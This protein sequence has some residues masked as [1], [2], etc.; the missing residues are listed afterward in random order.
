MITIRLNCRICGH[1]TDC[2]PAIRSE[3]S[4]ELLTCINCDAV[5][6]ELINTPDKELKE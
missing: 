4:N 2:Q 3:A 6:G 1:S 5:I